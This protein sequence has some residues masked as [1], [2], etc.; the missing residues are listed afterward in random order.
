MSGVN[1]YSTHRLEVGRSL[2]LKVVRVGD[3]ARS[4]DSLVGRV[5]DERGSPLALVVGV[6]DLGGRPHTT[7]RNLVT[8]GVGNL[9][10]DPVTILLVIPVLRLLSLGVGDHLRLVIQPVSGLLSGG[11]L[12]L[13]RGILVPVVGL[14]S[15]R[16]GNTG[17]IDPVLRLLVGLIINLLGRVDG[18]SEVLQKSTVLHRLAVNQD[19]EGLIRTDVKSVEGGELDIAHG[20]RALHVLLLV[21]AG[22]GVLVAEDEVDLVGRTTLVRA[23]HDDVGRGV[24][25]LIRLERLVILEEL[26]V[27]TTAL[28][29]L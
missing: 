2:V 13:I 29:T 16:V 22:L 27:G 26:H 8:L 28:E 9:G 23:K 7:A 4:P 3:L 17:L 20:D 11:I 5:V 6:L 21:L 1:T 12:N 18:R 15:L 25:E 24:G 14:G 19:L 10:R